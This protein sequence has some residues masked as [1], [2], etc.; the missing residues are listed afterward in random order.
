MTSNVPTTVR[1]VLA[2]GG[3]GAALRGSKADA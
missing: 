1:E 2:V 3:R